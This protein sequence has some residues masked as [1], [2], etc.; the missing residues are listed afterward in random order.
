MA[1]GETGWLNKKHG[2]ARRG[3]GKAASRGWGEVC[4]GARRQK[5]EHVCTP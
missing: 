5:T 1:W 4:V 3:I 2:E